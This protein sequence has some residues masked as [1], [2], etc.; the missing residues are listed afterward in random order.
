MGGM[1]NT[2]ECLINI[3]TDNKPKAL[4]GLSQ[5]GNV[6]GTRISNFLVMGIQRYR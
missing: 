1:A 5:H 3:V 2:C 6:A 4:A